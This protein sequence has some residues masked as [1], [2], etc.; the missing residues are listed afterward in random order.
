MTDQ[1][2]QFTP[3][4]WESDNA[5]DMPEVWDANDYVVAEC[6]YI[7]RHRNSE[8]GIDRPEDELLANAR[9]IAAA[10][11]GYSAADNS[12]ARLETLLT[13]TTTLTPDDQAVVQECI[14][15]LRSFLAKARGEH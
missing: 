14:A 1:K 13:Y 7:A 10:P 12:A 6:S 15:D 3:G 4:P 11:D 9:L 2:P 5:A 8:P